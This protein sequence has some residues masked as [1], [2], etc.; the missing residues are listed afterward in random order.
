MRENFLYWWKIF[1]TRTNYN[2]KKKIYSLQL[3]DNDKISDD[4]DDEN[5]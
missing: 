4:D 1:D 3:N 2:D 5:L